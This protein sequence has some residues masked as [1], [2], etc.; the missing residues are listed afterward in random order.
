LEAEAEADKA[1][2]E[3][4][5]KIKKIKERLR[6]ADDM[7]NSCKKSSQGIPSTTSIQL[8]SDFA[9]FLN[10]L[11]QNKCPYLNCKKESKKVKKEGANKI[12]L[13]DR[14]ADE[15]EEQ[16]AAGTTANMRKKSRDSISK[17]ESTA[18]PPPTEK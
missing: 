18:H 11:T 6:F 2:E 16:N 14:E 15:E 10:G 4:K 3:V 9:K 5:L 12:F 1:K 7:K 17:G 13:I 8:F